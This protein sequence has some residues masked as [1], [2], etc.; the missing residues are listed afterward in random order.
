MSWQAA[1]KEAQ[2][3]LD[4]L[5]LQTRS[6]KGQKIN[7]SEQAKGLRGEAKFIAMIIRAAKRLLFKRGIVAEI[8]EPKPLG[9]VLDIE[10]AQDDTADR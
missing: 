1:R 10:D 5:N 9:R 3:W 8:D 4:T 7:L 6:L 2:R